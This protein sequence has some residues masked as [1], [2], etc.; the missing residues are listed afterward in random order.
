MQGEH[1]QEKEERQVGNVGSVL[2]RSADHINTSPILNSWVRS[3]TL[4][5]AFGQLL[6][7][8]YNKYLQEQKLMT[9]T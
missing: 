8:P 3:I 9:Y 7:K 4:R 6:Q 5:Q 2:L 1:R